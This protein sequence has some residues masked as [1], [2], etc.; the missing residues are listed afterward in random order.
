M[1]IIDK[2]FHACLKL[3]NTVHKVVINKTHCISKVGVWFPEII[4]KSLALAETLSGV[5][6]YRSLMSVFTA[7]SHPQNR[8]LLQPLE[9]N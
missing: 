8:P 5:E 2:Q 4:K 1:A 9:H 3:I 7:I 6:N